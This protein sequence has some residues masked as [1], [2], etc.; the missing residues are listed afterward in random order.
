MAHST[1]PRLEDSLGTFLGLR[2]G[3]RSGHSIR[4]NKKH[5]GFNNSASRWFTTS[6]ARVLTRRIE[7]RWAESNRRA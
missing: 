1:F 5:Y 6:E 3:M 2:R 4:G 7:W